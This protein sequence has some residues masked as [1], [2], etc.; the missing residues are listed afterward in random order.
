[1]ANDIIKAM[2]ARIRLMVESGIRM[3]TIARAVGVDYKSLVAFCQSAGIIER[4]ASGKITP[5]SYTPGD[6]KNCDRCKFNKVCVEKIRNAFRCGRY[7]PDYKGIIA[8]IER[9]RMIRDWN[10]RDQIGG[11]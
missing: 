8:K 1:M 6:Y 4:T 2:E 11:V 3:M 5:K 7:Y 10:E 9:N